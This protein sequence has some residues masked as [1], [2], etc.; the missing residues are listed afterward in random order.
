MV[1]RPPWDSERSL[2]Q[3]SAPDRGPGDPL[4][5]RASHRPFRRQSIRVY[6]SFAE[7]EQPG[8]TP[9][10]LT[11]CFSLNWLEANKLVEY[12]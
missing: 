6:T 12:L 2:H 11:R 7:Q 5:N 10:P 9:Q 1:A 3:R 8:L 4:G